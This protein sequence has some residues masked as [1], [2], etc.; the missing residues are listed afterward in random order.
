MRTPGTRAD[1]RVLMLAVA[2]AAVAAAMSACGG[3]SPAPAAP[4]SPASVGGSW[5]AAGS[6]LADTR[7]AAGEHILSPANASRLT[8]AWSLTTA[9][10]VTTTPVVDDGT[11]YFPDSGGKLWAVSAAT[12]KVVWSRSVSGYT[13]FTSVARTSPAVAGGELVLGVTSPPHGAYVI[14]VSRRTGNLLWKTRADAN[15]AAIMTGAP[16]IY[17]GVAYEGVSSY[18]EA[19]AAQPGYRCCTFRGSVVALDAATGRLLW[20]TYTVPPGY[21]GGAVWGSTPAIDPADRLLYAGTGNNYTV[22]PGTCAAPG[23]TGCAPPPPADH[24]DS[25]LALDLATGAVRWHLSTVTGDAFTDACDQQPSSGCGTDFDFGS[26]PNLIRLPTGRQLL[27]IG[28]KSGIYWAL[29]P[30]TGTV[31]WKTRLGPGGGYGGIEWG[32]ATDGTRVYVAIADSDGTP[33]HITGAGGTATITGGSWAALD[34]AT[35]KI[36]WQAPDPQHA[37]DLGYLS[38]A[39]GLV[40]AGSTAKNGDDMYVLN[41]A[42]GTIVWRFASGGPVVSGAAIAGGGVYW[43]S[44]YSFATA[45]PNTTSPTQTCPGANNKLYAFRPSQS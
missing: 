44:G 2:S 30:A 22:P 41:A 12:A 24:V 38:T 28:Q 45:C 21:T 10:D 40:Y 39:N 6:D 36:L 11:V 19:L 35:G 17:Q 16:V 15:P 23:Q 29:D 7:D 42:A 4:A 32:S 9:G 5:P 13:G 26:G 1:R 31:T 8:T 3:P 37:A 18:E 34:A 33:Y 20:K 25:V 43:G 27:G 14:A